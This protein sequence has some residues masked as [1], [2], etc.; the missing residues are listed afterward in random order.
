MRHL[1][2]PR[3]PRY[4]RRAGDHSPPQRAQSI[5]VVAQ[6]IIDLAPPEVRLQPCC[7]WMG[8]VAG[9]RA[10]GGARPGRYRCSV[11]PGGDRA[12]HNIARPPQ[13]DPAAADTGGSG[14]PPTAARVVPRRADRTCSASVAISL[15][16]RSGAVAG[17]GIGH[18]PPSPATPPNVR[19]RA[20]GFSVAMKVDAPELA[21]K[22]ESGGVRLNLNTAESV[23]V[24]SHDIVGAPCATRSADQLGVSIELSLLPAAGAPSASGASR[25]D[26]RSV[27]IGA[28][29]TPPRRA[30]SR[31][32]R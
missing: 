19:R 11:R 1:A 22:S 26:L 10:R 15:S 27:I 6:D 32:H 9:R 7:C 16:M 12:V 3:T 29:G 4:Q 18:A 21:S 31:C 20:G 30:P 23:S 2:S 8:D 24:P 5:R 25:R 28:R 17:F 14:M 13:P